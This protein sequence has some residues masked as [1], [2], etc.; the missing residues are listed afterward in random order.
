MG[1]GVEG[2]NRRQVSH[3]G[4]FTLFV[5]AF[6]HCFSER[7]VSSLSIR[8]SSESLGDRPRARLKAGTRR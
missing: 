2:G 1:W 6:C 3:S 4:I 5:G 8:L 7:L